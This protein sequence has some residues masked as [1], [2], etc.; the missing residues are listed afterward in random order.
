MMNLNE[1]TCLQTITLIDILWGVKSWSQYNPHQFIRPKYSMNKCAYK[2][3]CK[4]FNNYILS[5]S[6]EDEVRGKKLHRE[7][8]YAWY[9][10][11]FSESV[12]ASIWVNSSALFIFRGSL[13]LT[14]GSCVQV[15]M[16]S[17]NKVNYVLKSVV[18][19]CS[20]AWSKNKD[21]LPS[22]SLET[23]ENSR[24]KMRFLRL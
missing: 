17:R 18:A 16:I 3:S 7:R 6:F 1:R 8:V 4:L 5:V 2:V 19:C 14:C 24:K 22:L 10:L 9:K 21:T 15:L 23:V 20:G 12:D 11:F 13:L